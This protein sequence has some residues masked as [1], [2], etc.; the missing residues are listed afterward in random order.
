MP[1][2]LSATPSG[3]ALGNAFHNIGGDVRAVIARALMSDEERT[4]L[5]TADLFDHDV[6]R[7]CACREL[8]IQVEVVV[9]FAS[10]ISD[11]SVG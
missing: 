9:E 2:V 8:G 6:V 3:Y 1:G 11:K 10:Q 7:V 5:Q 4:W